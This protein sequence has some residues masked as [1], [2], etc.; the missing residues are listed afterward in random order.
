MAQPQH[1]GQGGD[2]EEEE[3]GLQP[4]AAQLVQVAQPRHPQAQTRKDQRDHHHD[5]SAQPH[6]PGGLG[7][8]TDDVGEGRGFPPRQIRHHSARCAQD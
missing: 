1:R 6:L 8:V 7:A 5:Q 4:H 2:Q 3:H